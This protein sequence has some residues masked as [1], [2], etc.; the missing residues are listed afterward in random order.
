MSNVEL[1]AEIRAAAASLATAAAAAENDDL[2]AA[3]IGIED[4]LFR[5]QSLIGRIQQVQCNQRTQHSGEPAPDTD[6]RG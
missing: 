4:A 2:T 5:A 1:V 3:E 6:D